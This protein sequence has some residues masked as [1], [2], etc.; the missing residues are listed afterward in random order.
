MFLLALPEIVPFF[1]ILKNEQIE[2][3]N[4]SDSAWSDCF[5]GGG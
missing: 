4:F 5:S 2:N 1:L 3:G